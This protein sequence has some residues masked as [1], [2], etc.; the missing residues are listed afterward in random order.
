MSGMRNKVVQHTPYHGMARM[1]DRFYGAV[2]GEGPSPISPAGLV[3]P[4]EFV[5]ALL[6]EVPES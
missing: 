5:D 4:M 3:R 1:I 2:R 6:A